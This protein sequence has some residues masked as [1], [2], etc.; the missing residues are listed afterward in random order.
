LSTNKPTAVEPVRDVEKLKK[1][2]D[3][4]NAA[5]EKNQLLIDNLNRLIDQVID[6]VKEQTETIQL[7]CANIV[8]IKRELQMLKA[9][10]QRNPEVLKQ[11]LDQVQAQ[12]EGQVNASGNKG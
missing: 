11:Y 7:S 3:E 8:S 2:R 12:T 1:D 6:R 4:A 5:T 10:S 9:Q